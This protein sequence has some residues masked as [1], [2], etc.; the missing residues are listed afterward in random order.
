MTRFQR[1]PG[2]ERAQIRQLTPTIKRSL[3]G[4]W[5]RAV[6]DRKTVAASC[7]DRGSAGHPMLR[8]VPKSETQE[9]QEM[10]RFCRFTLRV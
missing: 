7:Q 3:A 8:G 6:P 1:P 10:T 2:F 5:L 9:Q 4:R